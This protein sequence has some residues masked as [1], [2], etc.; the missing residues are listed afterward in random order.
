MALVILVG[1]YANRLSVK[2]MAK[3]LN[4]IVNE[5]RLHK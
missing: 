3:L 2:Y 1:V 4:R 5:E